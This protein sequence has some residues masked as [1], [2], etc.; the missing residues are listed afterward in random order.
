MKKYDTYKPSGVEWLVEI[1]INLF[2]E[3]IIN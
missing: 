2:F 1:N 3:Y